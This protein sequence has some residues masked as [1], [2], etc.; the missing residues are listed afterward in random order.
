MEE[1]PT[2][3]PN[4]TFLITQIRAIIIR[5]NEGNWQRKKEEEKGEQGK[6]RKVTLSGQQAP[7]W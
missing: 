6:G 7:K 2:D 4:V 1:R 3:R 5:E